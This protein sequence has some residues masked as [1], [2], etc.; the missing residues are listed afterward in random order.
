MALAKRQGRGKPLKIEQRKV[1]G[2]SGPEWAPQVEQ[3]AP[4]AS[5]IYTGQARGGGKDIKRGARAAVSLSPA[6]WHLPALSP[7]HISGSACRH[8]SRMDSLPIF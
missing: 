5:P 7:L 6:R 2:R 1:K 8:A 3:T 4:L